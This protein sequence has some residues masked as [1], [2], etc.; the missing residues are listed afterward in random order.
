MSKR[1]A[2]KRKASNRATSEKTRQPRRIAGVH[3]NRLTAAI[4]GVA[5]VG[6]GL[7]GAASVGQQASEPAAAEPQSPAT[8]QPKRATQPPRNPLDADRAY[9]YLKDICAIGRRVSGSAGMKRQQELV[10]K[11]FESL[12]GEVTRQEFMAKNPRGGEVPMVNLIVTWHSDRNERVLLCA[13]Y[14]TRPLPDEE[15]DRAKKERGIFIGANDGGSGVAVMMELAHHMAQL[16]PKFG[17][18]FILFDGEELVYDGDRD[19]YFLGSQHFAEQYRDK[20]PEH[21]YRWGVL[22]DMVGDTDL[23]LFQEENSVTWRD[24]R[25]LVSQIWGLAQRLG[26]REFIARPK[27]LIRDDHLALRN[28]AKIPTCDVI[29]FDYPYWHTEGDTPDKCSG[30]SLAKVGWVV[31]EWFKRAE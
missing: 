14:D 27:Y 3:F 1:A 13:H 25:P 6:I 20:P 17:V 18:D 10:T 11:H 22:L 19:P 7:I 28:T 24:T 15:T 9:D 12:G 29:D 30:E 4:V 26:V 8:A 31:Y 5:L 23:Q 21:K 16:Q 2:K